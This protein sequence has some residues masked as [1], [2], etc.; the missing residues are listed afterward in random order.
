MTNGTFAPGFKV[1]LHHKDLKIC[2]AMAD[3]INVPVPLASMA[4]TDYA[5]LMAA[6]YGG[7]DISALF[8][9]KRK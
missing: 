2:Q 4:I 3:Q 1:A 8:R 5:K 7:E 6:G 9:L